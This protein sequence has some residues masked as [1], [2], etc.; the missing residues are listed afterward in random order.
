MLVLRADPFL[1]TL[2]DGIGGRVRLAC[3]IGNQDQ[4]TNGLSKSV[5]FD[6]AF[7]RRMTTIFWNILDSMISKPT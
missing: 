2:E 1:V 6:G 3:E 5:R 7:Q 4:M